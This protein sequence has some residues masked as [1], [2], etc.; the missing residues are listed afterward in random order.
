MP[1]PQ[2][3]RE[4]LEFAARDDSAFSAHSAHS[5]A[6]RRRSARDRE[7]VA[8]R[9]IAQGTIEEEVTRDLSPAPIDQ[10]ANNPRYSPTPA[11][12]YEETA[13]AD[14][15]LPVD[16]QME[17]SKRSLSDPS[18]N[19]ASMERLAF[20]NL[21][22]VGVQQT[23]QPGSGYARSNSLPLS[24]PR[25]LLLPNR[26]RSTSAAPSDRAPD[27]A[28]SRQRSMSQSAVSYVFDPAN[29]FLPFNFGDHNSSS[30]GSLYA[31][32]WR[33]IDDT[34]VVVE[35]DI[36]DGM[37][38]EP[39]AEYQLASEEEEEGVDEGGFASRFSR[40]EGGGENDGTFVEIR[41]TCEEV[42]RM[43]WPTNTL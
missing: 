13:L 30:N 28:I 36:E 27:S 5:L 15:A 6:L 8:A 9:Q 14:G 39:K 34:E 18:L 21:S 35:G 24:N 12:V 22:V 16:Q 42:R 23:L 17:T 4:A 33:T 31:P 11:S 10:A 26:S 2:P 19:T 41:D 38:V 29:P 20:D 7:E 1:P 40:F 25:S 43:A 3:P 32:E 37:D